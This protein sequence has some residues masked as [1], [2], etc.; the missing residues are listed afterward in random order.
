MAKDAL[1][2]LICDRQSR[3]CLLVDS[4]RVVVDVRHAVVYDIVICRGVDKLF[5]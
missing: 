2:F 5:D 3:D 4:S 1:A